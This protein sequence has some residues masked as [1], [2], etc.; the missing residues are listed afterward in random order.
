[1]ATSPKDVCRKPRASTL[2]PQ[3]CGSLWLCHCF[4]VPTIRIAITIT[5]TVTIPISIT[6]TIPI[7]TTINITTTI[8]ITITI[9]TLLKQ[10]SNKQQG[11]RS[12][13]GECHQN[14]GG[15]GRTT[16]FSWQSPV[17]AAF[18][19]TPIH[20]PVLDWHKGSCSRIAQ[21]LFSPTPYALFV[22]C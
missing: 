14:A 11:R 4:G 1:M 18:K 21:D 6:I 13:G 15:D 5:I 9:A 17:L 20:D 12:T 22:Q 19:L 16:A 10:R 3:E 2:A 8:S 7:T